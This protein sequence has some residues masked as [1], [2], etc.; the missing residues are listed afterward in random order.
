MNALT[1]KIAPALLAA[2]TLAPA[3]LAQWNAA[4]LGEVP[5]LKNA[6]PKTGDELLDLL[7]KA[8]PGGAPTVGQVAV[9]ANLMRN[10]PTEFQDRDRTTYFDQAKVFVGNTEV[11]LMQAMDGQMGL[12]I[13][14]KQTQWLLEQAAARKSGQAAGLASG[15]LALVQAFNE[16]LQAESADTRSKAMP[17]FEKALKDGGYANLVSTDAR[18]QS[19]ADEIRGMDVGTFWT[20]A[21]SSEAA[22][23]TQRALD[24]IEA[25]IGEPNSREVSQA[26]A[27]DF[28]TPLHGSTT[29]LA[30]NSGS[31][32]SDDLGNLLAALGQGLATLDS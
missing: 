25:E 1:K 10:L 26:P 22:V 28:S 21:N 20:W 6:N 32:S 16:A 4:T 27:V 18:V 15:A 2:L 12:A 31:A 7:N 9:P 30:S 14:G 5:A 19:A 3:A 23:L 24:I 29:D 13:D 11:H 17:L 8:F